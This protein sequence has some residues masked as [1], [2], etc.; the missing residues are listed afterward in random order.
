MNCISPWRWSLPSSFPPSPSSLLPKRTTPP[1]LLRTNNFPTGIRALLPN[2]PS[3]TQ[4]RTP[5]NPLTL[6]SLLQIGS[7]FS[8]MAAPAAMAVTGDNNVDEDLVTTLVTGGITAAFYLF[9]VPPILLN[10][11]R[12]RWFKRRLFEMYLQFMFVFIFFPGLMLWA[13]FV[14]FRPLPRDPTM[15]YP[16]ST[17]KDD[18]PI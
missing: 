4:R 7:I 9:V 14:N 11:L 10:W 5:T 3:A 18:V 1:S 2:R 17:P 16:W 12:L 15:K 6:P 8:S 13:P